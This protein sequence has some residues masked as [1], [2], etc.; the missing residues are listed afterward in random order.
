MLSVSIER[1]TNS[2]PRFY[3]LMG[4]YMARRDIV[5]ELGS[6]IWDDDDKLWF[7]AF[8]EHCVVGFASARSEGAVVKM[9]SAYVL[10]GARMS[11]VYTALLE[12]RIDWA[13]GRA[14]LAVATPASAPI[15]A[16]RGFTKTRA[17]GRFSVMFL[18]PT[19]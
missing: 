18:E 14:V 5:G 6:P 2:D 8:G 10:P 16:R 7:V 11:G 19:I 4:P 9:S 13:Q 1:M 15:L 17:K 3:G 12:A